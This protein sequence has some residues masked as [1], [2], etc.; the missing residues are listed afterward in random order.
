MTTQNASSLAKELEA[1]RTSLMLAGDTTDLADILSDD[2]YY[3]HSSGLQ[4]N[5][6]S[7]L[8]KIA[9]ETIVYR[10]LEGD[11]GRVIALDQSAFSVYGAVSMDAIVGGIERSVDYLFLA[12][13]RKE[14]DT[15]RL[16]ALQS[17][18]A[19]KLDTKT[20]PY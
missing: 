2:L 18:M 1:K 12:V 14:L 19:A 13:W 9:N 4:D 11:P 7:L 20:A 16:V 5:K 17:T 8:A 15:W 3:L 10:R 6:E